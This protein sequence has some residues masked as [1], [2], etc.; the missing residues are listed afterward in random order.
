MPADERETHA[1]LTDKNGTVYEGQ[2]GDEEYQTLT[3]GETIPLI[4][5]QVTE[6]NMTAVLE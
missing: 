1:Y 6:E 2:A 4:W 3:Q 5:Y